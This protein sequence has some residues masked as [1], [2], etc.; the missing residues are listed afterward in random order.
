MT[1][2]EKF[3]LEAVRTELALMSGA[4]YEMYNN[5]L[6]LKHLGNGNTPEQIIDSIEQH[7]RRHDRTYTKVREL[8]AM[9]KDNSNQKD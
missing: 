2:L 9:L 5:S 1:D 4:A 3:G 8:I 7:F 6:R